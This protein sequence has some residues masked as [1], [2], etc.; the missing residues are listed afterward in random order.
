MKQHLSIEDLNQLS[1]KGKERLRAWWYERFR[2]GDRCIYQDWVEKCVVRYD[3]DNSLE[4]GFPQCSPVDEGELRN[5]RFIK[6]LVGEVPLVY[7][8]LSVGQLLELIDSH[9]LITEKIGGRP[10]EEWCDRLWEL[11]KFQLEYDAA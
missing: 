8:L 10:K 6:I 9:T 7:P 2:A 4:V 1:E 3:K 11:A 5:D